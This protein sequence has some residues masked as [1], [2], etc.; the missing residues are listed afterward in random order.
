MNSNRRKCSIPSA[1]RV[2][3]RP[4]LWH[5]WS[6]IVQQLMMMN[7]LDEAAEI[8]R[9]ATERFPLLPRLWL[10]RATVARYRG[11]LAVEQES[12]ETAFRIN[13]SWGEA[14]RQLSDVYVRKGDFT[15]A[16]TIL[17]GAVA[18]DP[19]DPANR[20]GLA[21]VLW[22]L[23]EKEEA[24]QQLERAVDIA[25]GYNWAWNMLDN[26]CEELGQPGRSIDGVRRLV[27]KRPGEAR[28]WMM[29]VRILD[30]E[31]IDEALSGPRQ[32]D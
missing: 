8:A 13:P 11:D 24:I 26:W 17:E 7:Q 32:G 23:G 9:E 12:L 4:E 27:E 15:Q 6:A 10:D 21:E 1:K 16:K 28:S 29:L 2:Q 22:K 25:P 20:S 5:V 14:L 31:H 30:E 18:R 3:E 19:L